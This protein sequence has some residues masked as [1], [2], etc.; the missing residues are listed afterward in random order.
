V[1]VIDLEAMAGHRGSLFG[2]M[3]AQPS[4]RMFE[5]QLAHALAALD[6]ARPVVVEAESSKIGACRIPPVLWQAMCAAP[7][8]E[9]VA[10]RAARADYL[11]RT[12]TDLVANPA[13]LIGVIARLRPY[14]PAE[15]IADWIK[16][17]ERGDFVELA[18][19]L[20]RSHYDPR[21]AKHRARTQV[22]RNILP[23]DS[24]S[25]AA[26]AEVADQLTAMVDAT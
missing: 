24:L 10:P 7:R 25:P 4:Q 14:H 5:G 17:A 9:V 15:R 20:M 2:A 1:Q 22:P 16:L 12:Y 19:G 8:I 23:V 26:I 18:E 11:A 3:G 13:R 6:P 21:Y